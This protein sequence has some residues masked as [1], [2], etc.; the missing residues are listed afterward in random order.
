MKPRRNIKQAFGNR[1]RQLRE[2]QGYSQEMLALVCELDRSYMGSIERGQR[3]VALVNIG[4]IAAGLGIS[5]S[6]LFKGV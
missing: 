6:E 5:L 2:E 3:N 4:K 1:V